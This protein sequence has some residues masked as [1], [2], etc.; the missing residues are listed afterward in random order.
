LASRRRFTE[1]ED[2]LIQDA[3]DERF[4]GD[5]MCARARLRARRGA[6]SERRRVQIPGPPQKQ[7]HH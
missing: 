1:R 2:D 3:L 6:G 7:L 5:N 4:G